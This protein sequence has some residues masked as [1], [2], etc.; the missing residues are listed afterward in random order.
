[1]ITVFKDRH[2]MRD[3]LL[4]QF[5]RLKGPKK[6]SVDLRTEGSD[7]M[8]CLSLKEGLRGFEKLCG[9]FWKAEMHLGHMRLDLGK[10]ED[11]VELLTGVFVDGL[12]KPLLVSLSCD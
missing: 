11:C 5:K 8:M 7:V 9:R 2:T 10:T 3:H 1:M 4:E 6:E 12:V